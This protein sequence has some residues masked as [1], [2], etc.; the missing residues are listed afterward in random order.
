[1]ELNE[2]QREVVNYLNGPLRV[3]AGP[4]SGKTRTIIA[5]IEYLLKIKKVNPRKI[6]VITFTNKAANEI[7][8]RIRNLLEINNFNSVFTYHSFAFNFLKIEAENVN[9]SKNYFILDS[10]DQKAFI[11]KHFKDEDFITENLI[12]FSDLTTIFRKLRFGEEDQISNDKQFIRRIA[13][14]FER[15]Q[16]YKKEISALDFD[17]LII[18]TR[19]ILSSNQL[20]REK[21]KKRYDYIL[22]DEFQD[23]DPYQYQ[24]LKSLTDRNSKIMIV[25]DPDQ[26]IY[27]WRGADI[28]LI[29]DFEKDYQDVKTIILNINY[30]STKSILKIANNLI[31]NNKKR[32]SFDNIAFNKKDQKI[33]LITENLHR[34]ESHHVI[35]EIIRLN[36]KENV[37]LEKIAI[38][39]RSNYVSKE[40]EIELINRGINY[41]VVGGFRFFERKEVKETLNFLRFLILKDNHSLSLII[42]IPPRGIGE[43]TFAKLE[44]ES[45]SKRRTIW[46]GLTE[47]SIS[48]PKKLQP[49]IKETSKTLKEI[50][51]IK[52]IK[53]FSIIVKKYLN[54]IGFFEFYKNFAEEKIK[55]I[56]ALLE[57]IEQQFKSKLT[58]IDDLFEFLKSCALFSASDTKTVVNN[59]TLITVHAAKGLEFDAVFFVGFNENIIPSNRSINDNKI[60][61]E[62][63]I[64]YVGITRAKKYLYFAYFGGYDFY[65]KPWRPSRFI[66]EFN[67]PF[68]FVNDKNKDLNQVSISSPKIFTKKGF[69]EDKSNLKEG[70]IVYHQKFGEGVV[71]KADDIFAT[72]AFDKKYGIKEVLIE[73]HFLL[74]KD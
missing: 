33:N 15:Y 4:G 32:V 34:R 41:I 51:N 10:Q 62:R 63:R 2:K 25:G 17:D 36:H 57:L 68:D 67:Y 16:N 55:N 74:K 40:Y 71:V 69:V 30:R 49:F 20:I 59:L 37:P 29:F 8:E 44:N 13:K 43:K 54:N 7:N 3:I 48:V 65:M 35:N 46:K 72:V 61:E 70:D 31:S 22:V 26:N 38:L 21:W 11:K 73:H 45:I 64:A 42:N 50:D 53:D 9:L 14:L 6:L 23:I 12:D 60:E 66:H 47:E 58:L 28:N 18:F 19:D 56:E 39:Y 5:K 27:S 52:N 24:I 1:M